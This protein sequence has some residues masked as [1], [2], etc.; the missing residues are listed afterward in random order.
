V[1]IGGWGCGDLLI[2]SLDYQAQISRLRAGGEV[3]MCNREN[4]YGPGVSHFGE[5]AELGIGALGKVPECVRAHGL[6]EVVGAETANH[7]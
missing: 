1:A 5:Q 6:E 3:S 7:A 4:D 2:V